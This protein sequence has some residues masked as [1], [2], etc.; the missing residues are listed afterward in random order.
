[1]D[2]EPLNHFRY[3]SVQDPK[4]A[5]AH[6]WVY[7]SETDF[8]MYYYKQ[9]ELEPHEVRATIL[10]TGLCLSDSHTGRGKWGGCNYP[11]CPGHEV[12]SRI[13]HVGSAVTDR[14]VGDV[15][16][17]NPMR[18]ACFKCEYCIQGHTNLCLDQDEPRFLYAEHFGGYST[19]I[20]QPAHHS[21][22]IPEGMNLAEIPPLLCAGLTVFAPLKRF[23]KPGQTVGVMGIGGLGHL[24][25]RYA[26]K[27]GLNVIAFTT[28]ADKVEGIKALGASEVIV[29]DK[30]YKNLAQHSNRIHL[31]IN[32]LP[33][34]NNDILEAYIGT[35]KCNATFCVVGVPD[36]KE[37]LT[38]Q[39]FTLVMKQLNIVGSIVGSVNETNEMLQF[40]HQHGITSQNEHFDFEDFPKALDRLEN[41]KPNF[42]VVVDTH[43]Y[44]EKHFK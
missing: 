17:F 10:Y 19:H 5:D 27:M 26:S 39:F 18:H 41:G 13:T 34:S 3:Q 37:K 2:Q 6:A 36:I 32:T 4:E 21:F 22:K 12:I 14:K 15:V 24:A 11:C 20:Q 1:M 28:S 38:V 7:K 23:A 29:V 35:M 33:V 43:K 30:D 9:P 40:S 16:G 42:R 8:G 25:V 44:V 31:M